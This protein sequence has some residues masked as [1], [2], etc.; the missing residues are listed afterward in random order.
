MLNAVQC[1]GNLDTI[2]MTYVHSDMYQPCT[3]ETKMISKAMK[4]TV[5]LLGGL[6]V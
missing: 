6:C 2:N 4:C 5:G 1:V 3:P